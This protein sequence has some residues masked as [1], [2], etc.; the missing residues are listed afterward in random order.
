MTDTTTNIA[1]SIS[2][3]VASGAWTALK[4]SDIYKEILSYRT[5]WVMRIAVAIVRLVYH[6]YVRSEKRKA[7]G[8]KISDETASTARATA[9]VALREKILMQY[10]EKAPGLLS[11]ILKDDEVAASFIEQAVAI[12]KNPEKFK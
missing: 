9:I 4:A 10:G 12:S 8:D 2:A 3:I 5:Q 1:L 7:A 6:D 11:Q